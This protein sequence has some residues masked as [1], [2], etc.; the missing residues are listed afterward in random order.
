PHAAAEHVAPAR[1]VTSPSLAYRLALVAAGEGIAT[2][3][4][5]N[6]CAWDYAAGHA[7]LRAAG[8]A[9]VDQEGAPIAYAADGTSSAEL[10]FAGAPLTIAAL[11]KRSWSATALPPPAEPPQVLIRR[12]RFATAVRP[13]KRAV[14][15][16]G[17]LSRGQGCLLGQLCG[18]ALGGLV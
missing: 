18:D 17:L 4:L 2:L 3:S 11:R 8:G 10:C 16:A 6:P 14:P 7:L 12:A 13:P 5:N 15:D 9:L 1:Y